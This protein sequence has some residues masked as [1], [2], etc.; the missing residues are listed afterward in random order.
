MYQSITVALLV[1]EASFENSLLRRPVSS[2]FLRL[3]GVGF[4]TDGEQG[5]HLLDLENDACVFEMTS[6]NFLKLVTRLSQGL[7]IRRGSESSHGSALPY[8]SS[9]LRRSKTFPRLKRFFE[10]FASPTPRHRRHWLDDK[11]LLLY[12]F[13]G[14][15]FVGLAMRKHLHA[16]PF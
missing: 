9:T 14:V 2:S 12:S 1:V 10:N 6:L 4:L 16:C 8:R 15:A 7:H 3:F 13:F 11:S 5:K